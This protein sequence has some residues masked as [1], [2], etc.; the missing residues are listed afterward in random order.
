MFS[1]G[2]STTVKRKVNFLP[3]YVAIQKRR[4]NGGLLV[5]NNTN[6]GTRNKSVDN[7]LANDGF[8][9][10]NLEVSGKYINT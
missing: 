10:V 3:A 6:N 7:L 2:L 8:T 9:V 5:I 4:M 1:Y